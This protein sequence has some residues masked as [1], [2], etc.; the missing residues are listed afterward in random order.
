MKSNV[1]E[2][3]MRVTVLLQGGIKE[4]TGQNDT[5]I[6]LTDSTLHTV[7]DVFNVITLNPGDVGF[8]I[9][10]NKL[11]D[12]NDPLQDGMTLAIFPVIGGG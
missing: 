8:V 6:E 10:D 12:W 4:L 5:R 2:A 1:R 7:T 3:H 9:C 11:M